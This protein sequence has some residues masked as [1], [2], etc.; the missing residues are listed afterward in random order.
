MLTRFENWPEILA[1]KIEQARD[2]PFSWGTHDCALFCADIILAMSGSDLAH[3]LRGR[4]K[5]ESGALK[6]IR[7]LGFKNLEELVNERLEPVPIT[8][9]QRGDLVL[10]HNGALGICDGFVSWFVTPEG[11]TR[12]KTLTFEKAWKV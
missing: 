5:T 3:D 10:H 1:D 11:L 2:T 9:A 7:K 6:R 4:Y 8:C 12:V